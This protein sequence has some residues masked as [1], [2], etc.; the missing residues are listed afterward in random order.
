MQQVKQCLHLLKMHYPYR[1]GAVFI[2]NV[3]PAFNILWSLL[4]QVLPRKVLAKTFVLNRS[5][6]NRIICDK[7]GSEYVEEDYG[8]TVK[9]THRN[10]AAYFAAS[11]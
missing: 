7:L 2:V 1:L 11:K 4:K 10:T 9:E 5:S 3:N 6:S 8:G